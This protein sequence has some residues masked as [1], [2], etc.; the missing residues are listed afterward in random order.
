[1]YG[2]FNPTH[3]LARCG[4]TDIHIRKYNASM[5][6]GWQS[7]GLD[8]DNSGNEYKPESLYVEGVKSGE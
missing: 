5:F 4:F 6:H 8:M 3:L 2:R 1:M 7:L